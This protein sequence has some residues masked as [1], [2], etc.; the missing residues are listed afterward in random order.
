MVVVVVGGGGGWSWWVQGFK[1]ESTLHF[2]LSGSKVSKLYHSAV[3][4]IMFQ[5]FETESTLH[6]KRLEIYTTH[7][8]MMKNVDKMLSNILPV[9]LSFSQHAEQAHKI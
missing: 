3:Q 9:S 5:D 4:L 7:F 8:S 6:F 1:T 2:K